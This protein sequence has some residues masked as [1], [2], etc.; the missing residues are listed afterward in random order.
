MRRIGLLLAAVACFLLGSARP[1]SAHGRGEAGPS[2]VETTLGGV[3]PPLAGVR[4]RLVES[5]TRL[6]LRNDGAEV[7]VLGREGEPFLRV[8][9]EGAFENERSPTATANREATHRTPT[10][11]PVPVPPEPRWRK[12]ADRPSVRWHDH[13]TDAAEPGHPTRQRWEIPVQRAA[14]RSV[15]FGELVELPGRSAAPWYGLIGAAFAGAAVLGLLRRWGP[16][17]AAA[18]AVVLAADVA[19]A[20][21][22]AAGSADGLGASALELVTGSFYGLLGWVLAA[23]AIRLLARDRVD[24]LYAG[25]FAGLSMAVFGGLL[26]LALLSRSVF[27]SSLPPPLIR[28]CVSVSAGGGLGVAAACL[29]VIRRTPEARR[30][31][32]P[33][34]AAGAPKDRDPAAT[35]P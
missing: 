20:A 1:A 27:P 9:P 12:L 24:G 16:A 7:V 26:D 3:A 29:L 21:S 13:R 10:P 35:T 23:V 32:G 5:A 17:L 6:E 22:A 8:G 33:P 15:I 28:L 18:L 11:G 2:N 25:V 31:V 14:E 30:L 4:V 19:H 34:D